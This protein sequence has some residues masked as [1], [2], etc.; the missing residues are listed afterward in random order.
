ME[1]VNADFPAGTTTFIMGKSGSGKTTLGQLL[2]GF[3]SPSKGQIAIDGWPIQELDINWIRNN[4]TL[5]EQNN[6]LF[7][8]SM[9]TN[10]A[11]GRYNRHKEVTENE[12]QGGVD[13][14]MLQSVVD[15]LPHGINTSVGPGGRFLGGGE[16]QR[17]A[18]ARARLR[19]TPI[20]IMDEPT[21]ALDAINRTALMAAIRKWR[22]GKTTIII[23]HD[24]S[25]ILDNDFIYVME[26]G[27]VVHGGYR[28][29]LE[30]Q[31]GL[32]KYFHNGFS[33][34]RLR[35]ELDDFDSDI[36]TDM[37]DSI[38]PLE[39]PEHNLF[40][41]A[42][43]PGLWRT[44]WPLPIDPYLRQNHRHSQYRQ[45]R[46]SDIVHSFGIDTSQE[47]ASKERSKS[48]LQRKNSFEL[49]SPVSPVEHLEVLPRRQSSTIQRQLSIQRPRKRSK[50]RERDNSEFSSLRKI[51][52]TVIPN[53]KFRQ[54]ILLGMGILCGVLHGA[55][56]PIFAFCISQLFLAFF[57]SDAI[58]MYIAMKWSLIIIGVA[59]VDSTLDGA[60]HCNMEYAGQAWVDSL[61]NEAMRRL[62]DQPRT[63][64]EKEKNEA[65]KVT[66]C[67][68]RNGEDVKSIIGKFASFTLIAS[69]VST[70]AVIWSLIVCWRLTLVC[71]SCCPIVYIVAKGSQKA[72]GRWEKRCNDAADE[73]SA[74][75]TEIFTE[76]G[77]VRALT[78]EPYFHQKYLAASARCLKAGFEKAACMAFV[79]G[80]VDSIV[81]FVSGKD[82][83]NPP[84]PFSMQPD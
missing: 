53:L 9:Y 63:W 29:E 47:Q 50:S 20:L 83:N 1:S 70:V 77:T 2:N 46:H 79:Y 65:W 14:A 59:I 5:V 38:N 81:I 66:A 22:K 6:V 57:S 24:A 44:S 15:R 74:I 7:N 48:Q 36:D 49:T 64:F 30:N 41:N 67:L 84:S 11:F 72:I 61:S 69:T 31:P 52:P 34:I 55:L 18:I 51:L 39:G 3:Y 75:F 54:R 23:T 43:L 33:E 4:V 13:L 68:V 71:L 37:N 76:I 73:A 25:Q 78:L 60:L 12:V 32:E 19:D 10:I 80:T 16:R 27:S 40:G 82:S 26:H 28:Y 62:L 42:F 8:E 45:K 17:V 21:S 58:G 35:D 56:T